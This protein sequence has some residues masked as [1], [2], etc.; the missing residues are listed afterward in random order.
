MRRRGTL[1]PYRRRVRTVEEEALPDRRQACADNP[2]NSLLP[3]RAGED[4]DQ[5]NVE[6]LVRSLRRPQGL[7][8]DGQGVAVGGGVIQQPANLLR[9]RPRR[10][11]GADEC[12]HGASGAIPCSSLR[13]NRPPSLDLRPAYGVITSLGLSRPIAAVKVGGGGSDGRSAVRPTRLTTCSWA[14]CRS[15]FLSAVGVC[16]IW[17]IRGSFGGITAFCS[18]F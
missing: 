1:D 11:Q 16:H 18:D 15:T 10:S 14:P 5:L 2:S 6:R 8:N 9:L 17:D 4:T 3:Y 13:H 7:L 12:R